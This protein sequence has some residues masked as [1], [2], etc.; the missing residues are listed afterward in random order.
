MEEELSN[1][2][3]IS[4]KQACGEEEDEHKRVSSQVGQLGG[5]PGKRQD[6]RQDGK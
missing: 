2:F 6:G 3:D 4:N 5:R 1:A